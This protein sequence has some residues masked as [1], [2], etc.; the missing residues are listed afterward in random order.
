MPEA[1]QP[2]RPVRDRVLGRAGRG[3]AG[4]RAA[5]LQVRAPDPS[6]QLRQLPGRRARDD[7]PQRGRPAGASACTCPDADTLRGRAAAPITPELA[8]RTL[9]GSFPGDLGIE[10]VSITDDE[11]RGRLEVDRRHL[12]PGG[13]VHGGVWVAFADTVAAWGTCRHLRAGQDFTTAELK[14]NVFAAGA[15]RR[16]ARPPSACRCTSGAAPRPGR[17]RC[18]RARSWPPCS[19]APRS[20]CTRELRAR[21]GRRGAAGPARAR[22]ARARRVAARDRPS[23]RSR[24][25]A[26]GWPARCWRAGSGPATSCSR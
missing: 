23:A 18:T 1:Q 7:G 2:Q 26:R 25:A 4:Q 8:R 12:H 15:R 14:A 6:A 20:C 19:S 16:H 5:Q 10:L 17:S 21:R 24:T 22:G 13:Y 9:P 11:V 3:A